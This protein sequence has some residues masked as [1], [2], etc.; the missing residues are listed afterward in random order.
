MVLPPPRSWRRPH[1]EHSELLRESTIEPHEPD[2][3]LRSSKEVIDVRASQ[4]SM[5]V[6]M[7][8]QN[9]GSFCGRLFPGPGEANG[10]LLHLVEHGVR[11]VPW[12][13]G[14]RFRRVNG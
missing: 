12:H 3:L 2:R 7:L 1:I 4:D 13:S 10:E 5:Q 11:N 9:A 8:D 14:L 6:A